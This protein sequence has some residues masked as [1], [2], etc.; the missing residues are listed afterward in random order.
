MQSASSCVVC[1]LAEPSMHR[2]HGSSCPPQSEH[3]K[4]LRRTVFACR[5]L[6]VVCSKHQEHQALRTRTFE[7]LFGSHLRHRRSSQSSWAR[8]KFW[9]WSMTQR[10][11][12]LLQLRHSYT[13]R[14]SILATLTTCRV[15]C[16]HQLH[17]PSMASSGFTSSSDISSFSRRS[18]A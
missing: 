18:D 14:L 12:L 2:L 3:S 17:Q 4:T 8:A 15:G 10:I 5:S 9:H 11:V 1:F 6:L 16:R 7:T 13:L